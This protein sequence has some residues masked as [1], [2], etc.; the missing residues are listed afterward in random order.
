MKREDRREPI[1]LRE[2]PLKEHP[3]AG[4]KPGRLT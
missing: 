2:V 4:D 3:A 1:P